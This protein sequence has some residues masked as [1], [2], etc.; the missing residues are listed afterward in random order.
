ML[1]SIPTKRR[2][3][4]KGMTEKEI[5]DFRC[6]SCGVSLNVLISKE[7]YQ[8]KPATNIDLTVKDVCDGLPP[9]IL[10]DLTVAVSKRVPRIIHV[11][12]KKFLGK[13]NF[14]KVSKAIKAMQGE[15]VSQGKHSYWWVPATQEVEI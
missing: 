14:H 15:W 11:V 3:D 13:E 5:E 4:E 12:P 9:E 10:P 1:A 7:A 2:R 6:P 8:D